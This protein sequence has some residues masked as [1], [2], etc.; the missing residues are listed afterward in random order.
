M[1]IKSKLSASTSTAALSAGAASPA[2]DPAAAAT[3]RSA[4]DALVAAIMAML[5]ALFRFLT[6]GTWAD[7]K[8][9]V[10]GV[11]RA[12]GTARSIGEHALV[13]V[14][15]G[16]E[17]PARVLD[18][19]AGAVGATLGALLPQAP[20]GP[21]QVAQS[22][23]AADDDIRSDFERQS[24]TIKP[25]ILGTQLQLA[26]Q[27]LAGGD[28]YM[29]GFHAAEASPEIQVWLK[30]LTARQLATLSD[31]NGGAIEAHVTGGQR[32]PGLPPVAALAPAPRPA[33]L[34]DEEMKRLAERARMAFKEGP[35]RVAGL[36][37]GRRTA[38]PA[39]AEGSG[40]AWRHSPAGRRV[41]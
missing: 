8:R 10:A 13:A 39:E 20:V 37:P 27:C 1:A 5:T 40:P 38:L 32:Y 11:R 7:L 22:A 21:R 3:A 6:G 15:R 12:V 29:A 34:S 23:V 36:A 17:G 35:Q 33:A 2:A 41:H 19:T 24:V 9:D 28:G 25:A 16:L 26:A 18:A 4:L 30:G 14:G 31:L